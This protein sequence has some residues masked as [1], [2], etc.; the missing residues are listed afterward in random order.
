[1]V[2]GGALLASGCQTNREVT[3]PEP[4]PVDQELLTEALLT[5]DDVPPPYVV[6]EDTEPL[7]P[8]LLTEHECDDPLQELDPEES[9]SVT[10]TGAGL[11]T[12]LTN[13]VSYF[14]GQ[15][16]QAG[17]VYR[18]LLEDCEQAVADDEGV[19]F[20]TE[21]LDFGV[22]SDDTLPLVVVVENDDGTIE[23]RNLIVMRSG[24]LIST[25]RLDGP[26]PTD[27]VTLDA[28]T[29]VA[30]GNLGLLDQAT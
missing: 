24:D 5:A 17:D 7:G 28:V 23:E 10:F 6:A 2:V 4:L 26:R 29:R 19:S 21:P 8:E 11:G 18:D 20:T 12:T 9:A 15:G 27:L 16:A 30:I 13:T 14:P 1:M 25:I 22:L 3:R